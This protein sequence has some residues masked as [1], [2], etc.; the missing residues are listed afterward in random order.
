MWFISYSRSHNVLSCHVRPNFSKF[1]ESSE[2]I[3]V[4]SCVPTIGVSCCATNSVA[5]GVPL[6]RVGLLQKKNPTAKIDVDSKGLQIG[7]HELMV[8]K[9]G[10]HFLAL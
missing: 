10:R 7:M 2:I 3:G 4:A 8:A 6:V 5:Q 9:P 1:R